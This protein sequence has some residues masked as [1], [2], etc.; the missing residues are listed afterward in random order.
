MPSHAHCSPPFWPPRWDSA[1]LE[2]LCRI[3][4]GQTSNGQLYCHFI[5]GEASSR[6]V[7]ALW[8]RRNLGWV[9]SVLKQ[10]LL[11]PHCVCESLAC[12]EAE[13]EDVLAPPPHKPKGSELTQLSWHLSRSYQDRWKAGTESWQHNKGTVVSLTFLG[14]FGQ[15][16]GM[17]SH[18]RVGMCIAVAEAGSEAW[19]QDCGA[20]WSGSSASL[21][22]PPGW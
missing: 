15:G 2:G 21:L 12:L 9:G 11:L 13:A 14:S 18:G 20:G 8:I 6:P 22:C 3:K 19:T 17:R 10:Q 16:A 5:S 1:L 4:H 7:T